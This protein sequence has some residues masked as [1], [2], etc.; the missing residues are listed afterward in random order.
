M[1][2]AI[3]ALDIFTTPEFEKG[4]MVIGLSGWMDGG[5][6]STGA[7]ECLIAKTNAY[8]IGRIKSEEFYL[9][10]FPSAMETASL[11]RPY[12]SIENGII[13]EYQE[14]RNLFFADEINEILYFIGREPHL[15][16]HEFA[17][18]LID[19]AQRCGVREIFFTGSVAGLV[20]HSREPRITCTVSH[21]DMLDKMNKMHIK[22]AQY[23]GPGSIVNY[24]NLCA[25]KKNI[26]MACLVAE[27]PAYVQGKNPKCIEAAVRRLAALLNLEVNLE[28]LRNVSDKLEK[29]LDRIIAKRPELSE[30]IKMLETNY[31]KEVF[32]TEMGDLKKWLIQQGIRLD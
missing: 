17:D 27:I 6:V 29:K 16:W 23:E 22:P 4:R 24:L 1:H 28:D 18:C 21:D 31:D 3:E 9:Y 25:R 11:F 20:P 13:K 32:D 14:P 8:N 19:L 5:E 26:R 15:R 30:H 7:V 2:M 10:S 12:I